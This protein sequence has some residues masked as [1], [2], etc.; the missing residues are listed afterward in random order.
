MLMRLVR[1]FSKEGLGKFIDL[2]RVN[3]LASQ[4]I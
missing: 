2:L 1:L 4:F 3:R